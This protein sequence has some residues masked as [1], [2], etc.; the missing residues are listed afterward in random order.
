MRQ[1]VLLV[2]AHGFLTSRGD[3]SGGKGVYECSNWHCAR[4]RGA[5]RR[6]AQPHKPFAAQAHVRIGATYGALQDLLIVDRFVPVAA[7]P[8]TC[9]R[10]RRFRFQRNLTALPLGERDIPRVPETPNAS[11]AS[12]H[13]IGNE[14]ARELG[15]QRLLCI[16]GDFAFDRG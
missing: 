2:Q 5:C 4:N 10:Y 11:D 12:H 3:L 16:A 15:F 6:G 9:R 13:T 14:R 1:D 7:S 8:S